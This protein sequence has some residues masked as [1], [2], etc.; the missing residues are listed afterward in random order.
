MCDGSNFEM[1][2]GQKYIRVI[3]QMGDQQ[4]GWH[5]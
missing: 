2:I 3:A 1:C 5:A 4:V